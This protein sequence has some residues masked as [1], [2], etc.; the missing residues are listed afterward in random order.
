MIKNIF[1]SNYLELQEGDKIDDVMNIFDTQDLIG[2]SR[3]KQNY[4]S[5]N[6]YSNDFDYDINSINQEYYPLEN[7]LKSS[8]TNEENLLSNKDDIF[9][10]EAQKNIF[11]GKKTLL[12][13]ENKVIFKKN[14][15]NFY[16]N[17]FKTLNDKND[18]SSSINDNNNNNNLTNET[19]S[20]NNNNN[21]NKI[22]YSNMRCDSLL[23]KFKSFLGK[24]FINFINDKLKKSAKRRIK[25]FSF[26]YKKFT[27]NVSYSENQKWF[28]EKMKDLLVLGS[29]PNQLKNEKALKSIYK[30][31]E[32]EFNEI[33]Y[34]LELSYK[35]II[36]RFYHSNFFEIFKRQQKI[37]QLDEN[38]KKVMNKSI[39]D[40]DG[41]INF[42]CSRK[43]NKGKQEDDDTYSE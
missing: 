19:S 1:C 22:A 32:E 2:E 12:N 11:L 43:G 6:F 3:E 23:I 9:P 38:F 31:K 28:N 15:N 24:S 27:L 39:L 14:R 37:I 10:T 16:N 8:K 18:K 33:K 42:I 5:Y 29:E 13:E 41:F 4:I 26:N 40:Q 35:E 21:N 7:D 20:S 36:Q 25:L 30:R 34:L 17:I